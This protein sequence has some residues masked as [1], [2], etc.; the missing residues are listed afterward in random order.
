MQ[1]AQQAQENGT[2]IMHHLLHDPRGRVV[3]IEALMVLG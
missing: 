3:S 2:S 1:G